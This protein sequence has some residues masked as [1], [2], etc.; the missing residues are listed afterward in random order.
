MSAAPSIEAAVDAYR[1]GR[2]D[3]A[4]RLS[5]EILR[6]TPDHFA[7]LHLLGTVYAAL[8]DERKALVHLE[9]ALRIDPRSAEVNQNVAILLMRAK[10]FEDAVARY[11]AALAAEPASPQLHNDLGTA[12]G[13]LGWHEEARAAFA[14]ALARDP[15]FVDAHANLAT[16]LARLGRHEEAIP[17]FE[18][19]LELQPTRVATL[20]HLGVSLGAVERDW[21]ALTSVERALALD[22]NAAYAH[23]DRGRALERMNRIGEAL[24]SYDRAI[25]LVPDYAAAHFNRAL[26]LLRAG[27]YEHGW[28]AYEWRWA[29]DDAASPEREFEAPLWLGREEIRG[30]SILLHAEQGLGDTIQFARYVPMV[31]ARGARVSLEVQPELKRLM[32]WIAGASAVVGRGDAVPDFD[33]HCPLGSLPLA[34]GTTLENVPAQVPYLVPPPDLVDGWRKRLGPFEGRRVG[35][36]WSGR[37]QHRNDR[38]RSIPLATLNPLFES[39]NGVA[40]EWHALQTEFR[41]G[42]LETVARLPNVRRHRF[43]DFAETAGLI[44]TLDLVIA[45]DTAAAHLA[46][47]MGKPVWILLP[48]APDWRWMLVRDDSAWYPSAHLFRQVEPGAWAGVV[49][50]VRT[51]LGA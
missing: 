46:G 45:A 8:G 49:A 11:R 35:I 39:A 19:A 30:K 34:L 44:A 13:A 51:A 37:A 17:S 31:A 27:D 25:A 33:L 9:A 6:A 7:A 23:N 43:E 40:I 5:T 24:R 28:E 22:P 42:D 4:R 26:A 21:E 16:A 48:F 2:L 50:R 12:L 38:R 3:E 1:A 14:Q 32:S 18:R 10:R 41:P 15:G 29:G 36:V 20:V 47:A